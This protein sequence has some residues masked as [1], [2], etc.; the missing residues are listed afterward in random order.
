MT[1][2]MRPATAPRAALVAAALLL[3]CSAIRKNE[4]KV[5]GS[6]EVGCC[7]WATTLLTRSQSQEYADVGPA[8]REAGPEEAVREPRPG[9]SM[10]VLTAFTTE[11]RGFGVPARDLAVGDVGPVFSKSTDRDGGVWWTVN[12][13]D[14]GDNQANWNKERVQDRE[15]TKFAAIKN[16]DLMTGKLVVIPSPIQLTGECMCVGTC[17]CMTLPGSTSAVPCTGEVNAD[18]PVIE[19][20]ADAPVMGLGMRRSATSLNVISGGGRES[21]LLQTG[22]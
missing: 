21:P 10:K 22:A 15:W 4:E 16:D 18:A 3:A 14:P 13:Y 12:F 1:G 17:C 6:A 2:G 5:V 11:N 20:P 19:P 8:F 9:D 7:F